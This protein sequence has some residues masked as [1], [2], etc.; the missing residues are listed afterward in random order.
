MILDTAWGPRKIRMRVGTLHTR[1][2]HRLRCPIRL[3]QVVLGLWKAGY[4]IHAFIPSSIAVPH[5]FTKIIESDPY[6]FAYT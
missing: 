4:I 6:K 2:H 5:N 3:S 1:M